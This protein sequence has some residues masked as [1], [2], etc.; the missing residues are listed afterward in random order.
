MGGLSVV[1]YHNYNSWAQPGAS[2]MSILTH[3][4]VVILL[5]FA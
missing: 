1:T 4:R 5:A 3:E 2:D